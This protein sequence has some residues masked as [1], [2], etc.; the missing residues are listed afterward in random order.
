ML[1]NAMDSTSSAYNG[2]TPAK[3]VHKFS[4]SESKDVLAERRSSMYTKEQSASSFYYMSRQS[5]DVEASKAQH[6]K[7][8]EG[9]LENFHRKYGRLS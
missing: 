1:S 9:E 8:I 4:F 6:K 3:A 5:T 7:R 2:N